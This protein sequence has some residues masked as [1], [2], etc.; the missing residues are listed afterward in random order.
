MG[1]YSLTIAK[2]AIGNITLTRTSPAP[3]VFHTTAQ[4]TGAGQTQVGRFY[5]DTGNLISC[6][7]S[8]TPDEPGF[9]GDYIQLTLRPENNWLEPDQNF[10][11]FRIRVDGYIRHT[12]GENS[13]PNYST[14]EVLIGIE[15]PE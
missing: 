5:S 6:F 11:A 2:G 10:C 1:Q 7:F 9:P 3:A 14:N 4:P 15:R 12:D 8:G 13:N